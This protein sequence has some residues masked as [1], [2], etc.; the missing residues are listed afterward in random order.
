MGRG[1]RGIQ[2]S[3]AVEAA[4]ASLPERYLGGGEERRASVE[5]R[6]SDLGRSWAIEL[7]DS[8]C[9]VRTSVRGRPDVVIGTDAATWLALRQGTLSGL[10]AFRQRRLWARGDLDVALGFEGLFALPDGRAPLLRV[11]DVQVLG[12]RISCL[13]AGSGPRRAILLHGLG[14]AKS[15]FYE[16]VAALAPEH[17]VHAIDLPGFGSSSKPLASY[18]PAFFARH[19]VALM[20]ALAIDRAD[21][22]GNSMGGRVAL[23]VGLLAPKRVRTL[24]LLAPSMAFRRGRQLVPLARALRPELAVLP[25]LMHPRLVQRRFWSLIG[26]PERV[27]PALGDIAVHEF[28]RTHRSPAA[29]VAFYAAARQIYLEQPLGPDGFWTRLEALRPPALFVWGEE[30][31]V[32]PARFARHVEAALPAAAQVVL[33]E[34][35]HVPQIELPEQTHSMV[36]EFIASRALARRGGARPRVAAARA[37]PAA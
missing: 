16:T 2:L 1:S 12:T 23:E 17:T 27:D 29:R 34:C 14:G 7:R 6:L 4:F 28:L 20:D 18:D 25:P 8:R 31:R 10:D 11:H 32:V 19:V 22:V 3:R 5:V 36:R 30:D 15:S 21:L 37:R 9:R 13:T 26:R 33:P 24:S 35:G